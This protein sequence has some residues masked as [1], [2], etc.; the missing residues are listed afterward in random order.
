MCLWLSA[1]RIPAKSYPFARC[2]ADAFPLS[3]LH[4]V[5][6]PASL[7][8]SPFSSASPLIPDH[9]LL[10]SRARERTE[11]S[12]CVSEIGSVNAEDVGLSATMDAWSA[13]LT[14]PA[15]ASPFRISHE[16]R[17]AFCVFRS[18]CYDSRAILITLLPLPSVCPT[19]GS[20]FPSLFA[21]CFLAPSY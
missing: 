5:F 17:P 3:F 15:A 20:S 4:A 10:S 9:M 16:G 13:L 1:R 7:S 18:R 21:S 11:Q 12:L 8:P 2:S 6:A 19:P 14:G